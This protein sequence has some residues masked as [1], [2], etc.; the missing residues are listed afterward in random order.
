MSKESCPIC[1]AQSPNIWKW[2]RLPGHTVFDILVISLNNQ[3]W[4]KLPLNK[5]NFGKVQL[6]IYYV[7]VVRSLIFLFSY[8]VIWYWNPF[9]Y[10]NPNFRDVWW[11][12]GSLGPWFFSFLS[13][14]PWYV[15]VLGLNILY[16]QEVVTYFI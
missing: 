2:T 13:M 3:L 8:V 1:N 11:K 14:S 16:V 7:Y 10:L 6:M 9:W 12:D 4:F 5:E 15:C